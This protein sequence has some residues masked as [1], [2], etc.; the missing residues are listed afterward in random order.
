MEDTLGQI[1]KINKMKIKVLESQLKRILSEQDVSDVNTYPACV[2]NE[3]SNKNRGGLKKT[4][5]GQYY[6][7]VYISGLKGFQFYNNGK[8]LYPDKK[9]KGNYVC[10]GYKIII[11]GHDTENQIWENGKWSNRETYPVTDYEKRELKS[12]ENFSKNLTPHAT[13]TILQMGALL[14]PLV[15]PFISAGIGL[16]D[17]YLYYKE[18][19]TKTAG[20]VAMFS[21]LPG[22]SSVISK[23]P[24]LKQLG[25][26]GLSSLAQKI[27]GN[28]KLTRLEMEVAESISK[29]SAL[30]TQE[31]N[32]SIKTAA[33][34]AVKSGVKNPTIAAKIKNFAVNGIVVP[35]A[36]AA[37]YSKTYDAIQSNT[38]KS[39]A[40]KEGFDWEMVKRGFGSSGSEEDNKILNLAWDSG[41]RPGKVVPIK[42]Q[43]NTYKKESEE[44]INTAAE[45]RQFLSSNKK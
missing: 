23:I 22:V 45:L 25:S 12:I 13:L 7:E 4:K 6:I 15:G 8:V 9:T 41:W 5:T 44:E 17:A 18:G 28:G 16:G 2:A 26:K 21:L 38:P 42:Y 35:L 31:I 27:I 24:G 34:E 20:L 14:I 19:D 3:T 11:D 37:G 43:T 32:T 33:T 10:D 40:E 1:K 39:K 29:N 30:I 36:Q